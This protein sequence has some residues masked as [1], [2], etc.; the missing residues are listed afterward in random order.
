[1]Q[2]AGAFPSREQ[3]QSQRAEAARCRCA[4]I[5]AKAARLRS[6]RTAA[7]GRPREGGPFRPR[8]A[9]GPNEPGAGAP[10]LT[11]D[12]LRD[13]TNPGRMRAGSRAMPFE[14]KRTRRGCAPVH[15]RCLAGRNEPGAG[16]PRFTR[17]AFRDQTNPARVRLRS[18]AM[19]CGTKRTW[20][21]CA[22]V[23]TRCLSGPNEP[24]AGALRFTRDAFRDQTNLAR[25]L[26]SPTTNEPGDV[27]PV[28][29]EVAWMPER[30]PLAAGAE[31]C[32]PRCTRRLG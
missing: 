2:P 26:M 19:H 31:V 1:M 15:A 24:G 10:P 5:P 4:A 30:M 27:G 22:R 6:T 9:Q 21:G 7:L 23:H 3:P 29:Q 13:Q 11:R 14:T 17:D 8:S 12:G 32:Q 16:A 18:H 25:P 20:R 28:I